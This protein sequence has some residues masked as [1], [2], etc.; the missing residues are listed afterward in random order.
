MIKSTMTMAT[1]RTTI[2][3]DAMPTAVTSTEKTITM[4]HTA[5]TTTA[6]GA[7]SVLTT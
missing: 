2:T 7:S 4:S 1:G 3:T 5:G 6:T